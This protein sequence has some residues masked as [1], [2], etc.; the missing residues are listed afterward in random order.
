MSGYQPA[1]GELPEGAV[2][3]AGFMF[4]R[5]TLES[6]RELDIRR[7][8]RAPSPRA[9]VVPRDDLPDDDKFAQALERLGT[10]V[11]RASHAGFGG[12]MRDAHATLVP[13]DAIQ[14]IV[15]WAGGL[16]TG[17]ALAV[18]T[19]TTHRPSAPGN[20]LRRRVAG[21]ECVHSAHARYRGA[22]AP[23]P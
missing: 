21:I 1:A 2:M 17:A 20:L 3:A 18:A 9:L 14:G 11:T 19:E 23:G 5:E 10:E 16:K 6:L 22:A 13:E 8:G 7:L 12:M 4:S 15:Q